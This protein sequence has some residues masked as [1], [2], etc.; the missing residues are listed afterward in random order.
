[1][2][3]ST[4]IELLL[5]PPIPKVGD[6]VPLNVEYYDDGKTYYSIDRV[7]WQTQDPR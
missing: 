4:T 6:R 2:N 5:A 7:E 3:D 1:M